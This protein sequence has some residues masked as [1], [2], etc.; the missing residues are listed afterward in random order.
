MVVFRSVILAGSLLAMIVMWLK[1]QDRPTIVIVSAFW[2]FLMGLWTWSTGFIGWGI[3]WAVVGR[4]RSKWTYILGMP[5]LA[6]P[7]VGVFGLLSLIDTL[8]KGEAWAAILSFF[9]LPGIKII[10]FVITGD[11][12]PPPPPPSKDIPI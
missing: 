9:A 12:P 1:T 6:L 11:R 10:E 3:V 7:L 5:L 4:E 2:G 8:P